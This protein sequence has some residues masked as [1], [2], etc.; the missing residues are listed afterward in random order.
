MT[1]ET[2]APLSERERELFA[3][4]RDGPAPDAGFEERTVREARRAGA[5]ARPTRGA[6]PRVPVWWTAAAAL[7]GL[8]AGFLW[9]NTSGSVASGRQFLLLLRASEET[10]PLSPE[11][12]LRVAREYGAWARSFDGEVEGGEELVP[13]GRMLRSRGDALDITSS[14]GDVDGYFL[15]RAPGTPRAEEIAASCPHLTYGGSIELRE[16]VRR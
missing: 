11:E 3:A 2:R 4:L 16:I 1:D 5:L 9:P 12:N 13:H 8:L 7:V 15:I 14:D 10:A 6:W